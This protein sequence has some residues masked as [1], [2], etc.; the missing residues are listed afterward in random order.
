MSE[1]LRE[2]KKRETRERIVGAALALFERDGFEATTIDVIAAS[3]DI[4]PR[5]FFHYFATKEDVV[6][7]DYTDRLNRLTAVLF[8][9]P[10]DEAPWTALRE[11]FLVVAGDYETARPQ[12]I[13][14]FKIMAATPSVFARSLQ[15]QAVW[16]DAVADAMTTRLGTDPDDDITPLLLAAAALAAMRA[17]LRHWLANG[18]TTSLPALVTDCFMQLTD[19]FGA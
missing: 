14:R 2:R 3:V 16:E 10:A 11:S 7:A 6:L 13:R 9:R 17:S 5:T 18:A 12:L 4:A 19:G 1:G 8:E 15:L